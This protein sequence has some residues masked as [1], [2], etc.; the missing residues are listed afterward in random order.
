MD[1]MAALEGVLAR[2]LRWGTGI[3]SIVIILGLVWGLVGWKTG[4]S[5]LMSGETALIRT[6]IV[7]FILLPIV[8]VGLMLISFAR[9]RDYRFSLVAATVLGIIVIGFAFNR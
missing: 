7:L 9:Q 1:T 8:R 6:G 4:S 5:H 2:V 3:A